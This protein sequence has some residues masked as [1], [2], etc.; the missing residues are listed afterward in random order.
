MNIVL[1]ASALLAFVHGEVGAD[2]V[3]AAMVD[4]EAVVSAVNHA[5][6]LSKLL[7]SPD[8]LTPDTLTEILQANDGTLGGIYSVVDFD[9]DHALV[10][11]ALRPLTRHLGLSLGDRAC[12][13]LAWQLESPAITAD[14]AWADFDQSIVEVRLIR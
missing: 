11:G 14:R 5:E 4:D 6:V 13:A 7:D 10:T 8:A 12:L 9:S 2:S 3:A 1:D